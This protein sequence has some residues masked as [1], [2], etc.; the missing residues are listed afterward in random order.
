MALLPC[1]LYSAAMWLVL[2]LLTAGSS[3]ECSLL[4]NRSG[5]RCVCE[6][7]FTGG[8]CQQ[9]D[10]VPLKDLDAGWQWPLLDA[11]NVSGWGF[12]AVFDESDGLYH[13]VADVSCGCGQHTSVRDCTEYTGVLASGG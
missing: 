11:K 5:D 7:G 8:A 1:A 12:D 9:L 6:P 10:L 4:G 13:A 3:I 2:P